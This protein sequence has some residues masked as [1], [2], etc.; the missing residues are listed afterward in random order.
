MQRILAPRYL[1]VR[2]RLSVIG[3]FY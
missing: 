3:H 1:D 2:L